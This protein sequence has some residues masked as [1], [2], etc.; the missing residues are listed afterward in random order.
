MATTDQNIINIK[1]NNFTYRSKMAGFDYDH[2]LVKPKTNSTF[3]KDEND[4]MWL[5]PN[6]PEMLIE[7]YKKGYAIVIFTN[8]SNTQSF[9]IKQIINVFTGLKLPVNIFIGTDKAFKKPNPYMYN[10]YIDKRALVNKKASFY[11]GDALGRVGDFADSDKQ[12]AINSG[13]KYISPEQI[14][15][16]TEAKESSSLVSIPDHREIVLMMGYP[17]SGKSSFAEKAFKGRPYIIIHGDDH[18]SESQ[19][20]KAYKSAIETHSDKSIILDATHSNKKKRQIF[21]E[22]AEKANI[23]IRLIHLT[24][25][26]E[27]SMHRNLQREK[28]VPKIA[29]YLYRKHF[30]KAELTEGLFEII[31]I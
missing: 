29:L 26:I 8:Q 6:V 10:V 15:P 28:P 25:S 4:W 12:F 27:E 21:I 13:I 14:F 2:T 11:V 5:R 24:T 30:E 20:K 18:N 17:G 31:D 9:K 7:I 22:I 1:L 23:P 3:S 19:L 16:F